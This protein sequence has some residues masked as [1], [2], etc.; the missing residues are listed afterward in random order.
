MIRHQTICVITWTLPALFPT[1]HMITHEHMMTLP[2][3]SLYLA[4]GRWGLLPMWPAATWT[5]SQESQ[6][7][8]GCAPSTPSTLCRLAPSDTHRQTCWATSEA[9]AGDVE[10]PLPEGR[11]QKTFQVQHA[12]KVSSRQTGGAAQ[13][14]SDWLTKTMMLD[15]PSSLKQTTAGNMASSTRG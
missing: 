11:S 3:T 15:E 1:H 12:I 4:A 5:M 8:G 2:A 10:N 9:G 6:K 14:N 7:C 13:V